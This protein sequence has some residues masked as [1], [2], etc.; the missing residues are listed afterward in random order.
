M[1]RTFIAAAYT[2]LYGFSVFGNESKSCVFKVL[3]GTTKLMLG[4]QI[5][6][7]ELDL[8]HHRTVR[9]VWMYAK[10]FQSKICP[11]AITL[12]MEPCMHAYTL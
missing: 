3:H 6:Y 4:L 7:I 2:A 9:I 10:H 1:P 11:T 5:A 8:K 12:W